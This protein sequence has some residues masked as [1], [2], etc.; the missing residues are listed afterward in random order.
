M[1]LDLNTT[2]RPVD[3]NRFVIQKTYLNNFEFPSAL[4]PIQSNNI[5]VL[6]V[7]DE[8]N[9][10]IITKE[11]LERIDKE[12][13]VNILSSPEEALNIFDSFDCIVSDY[14]M[15]KMDGLELAINIR[16][17]SSVP[18]ILYTAYGDEKLFEKAYKVGVNSCL[19]KGYDRSD[20]EALAKQIRSVV[21]K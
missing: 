7:D 3:K 12:I 4:S 8:E 20:F 6:Y 18:F 14:K 13:T 10:L 2:I 19:S 21:Q 15:P 1:L 5:R 9:P 16:K 17:K 11:Y